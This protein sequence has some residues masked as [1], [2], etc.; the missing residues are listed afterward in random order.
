MVQLLPLSWV[1]IV[2]ALYWTLSVGYLLLFAAFAYFWFG[3]KEKIGVPKVL[4]GVSLV[5]AIRNEQANL[6]ALFAQLNQL[7]YPQLEVLLVDDQS[8]DGSVALLQQAAEQAQAAGRHWQV[9]QSTGSGKKAAISTA[10][11]VARGE[12]IVT[13]DADCG[14]SPDWISGLIAPFY[15][16]NIQL[17]A[18]PVMTTPHPH[19]YF[20]AFQQVEWSSIL[21]VT[22][23]SF[24]TGVPFMCSAA[25]MAYR[26]AAFE[27]VNGYTGNG[28]YLSG[29][30]EFLL[31]KITKKYGKTAFRYLNSQK[32]LVR[33][34]PQPHWK[35]YLTQRARWASKWRLHNLGHILLALV[36]F[37]LQ[38]SFLA[39]PFLL[40]LGTAGALTFVLLWACKWVAEYLVVRPI[41]RSFGYGLTLSGSLFTCVIHPIYA[42][43][44]AIWTLSGRWE[45]K[46]RKQTT[47]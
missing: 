17:V 26:K 38:L 19:Y 5:I 20:S 13:T 24:R 29:D 41:L 47:Q 37:A 44:T 40:W 11:A 35:A 34:M 28:Q 16:Q 9:L 2:L 21:L 27:A 14:F 31:K 15:D 42:M 22:H 1:E 6:A 45:W 43:A 7:N 30:D 12:L 46:G 8:E 32:L 10:L 25:N 39:S 18:G 33:T 23:M 36:P 4:P 3:T